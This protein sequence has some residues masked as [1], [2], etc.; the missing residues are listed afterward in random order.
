M[1][2][3]LRSLSLHMV[4]IIMWLLELADF[5]LVF[6]LLFES[7]ILLVN[8][9]RAGLMNIRSTVVSASL[10]SV[11]VEVILRKAIMQSVLGLLAWRIIIQF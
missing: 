3:E 2:V 6:Y 9:A 4:E 5:R 11:I 8:V 7:L 1:R 10:R